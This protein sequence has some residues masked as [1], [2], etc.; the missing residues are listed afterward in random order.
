MNAMKR[1][2]WLAFCLP[3]AGFGSNGGPEYRTEAKVAFDSQEGPAIFKRKKKKIK[4]L[5]IGLVAGQPMGFGGRIT[6]QPGRFAINGDFGFKNVRSDSGLKVGVGVIKLDARYYAGGLFGALL[7]PYAFGGLT[8]LRGKFE[9]S[10]ES[11]LNLD[12]GVGAGIRLGKIGIDVEAGLLA[13]AYQPESFTTGI[14]GFTN[15]SVMYWPIVVEK[16]LTRQNARE[17]RRKDREREKRR[18]DRRR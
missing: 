8:M 15:V 3:L 5:G 18:E 6:I 2:I 1:L 12:A 13:P 10:P 17:K 14:K 9:L 4:P 16:D 11:Q 7:R